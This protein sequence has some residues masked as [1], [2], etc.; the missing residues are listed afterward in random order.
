MGFDKSRF[1]KDNLLLYAVT[2]RSCLHGAALCDRVE[3]ALKGGVTM[4]QLR[5]KGMPA[6]ELLEEAKQMKALCARY[7]VP[8]II[9]DN[10]EVAKSADADG[11][12]I[13]QED[14]DVPTA[15]RLL[16]QD[17]LIGVSA[18]TVEQA[19]LAWEQGADYLGVGAVFAT[20]TK[21]DAQAISRERLKAVCE[22]VPIPVV[23]IGGITKDNLTYLTGSGISGAA[24]ASAIFA[25]ADT[26]QAATELKERA[27]AAVRSGMTAFSK[28]FLS[29]EQAEG[30]I[31]DVD[32]TLLDSMPA[33]ANSGQQYLAT[34]GI[35]APSSLGKVLFS[36]TMQ[37]GAAYIRQAF[38]LSQTPE[39]IKA[40]IIQV[41]ERA[42]REKVVCKPGAE[43]FLK[44]LYEA[45]IPMAVVTSND[46]PLV[47]A[48]FKRLHLTPYFGHILTC[49]E[50]G[51]GK[52][53]PAIFHAA[54]K[55]LGS[56][57]GHTWI[58]EDG[59][60]AIRTAKQA[61]YRTI[62]VAD[63]ASRQDE[64]AIRRLSDYFITDFVSGGLRNSTTG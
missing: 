59:L 51:S 64:E 43:A 32:G 20:G 21:P 56:S 53:D 4:V 24:A 28:Q 38:G 49:G 1:S 40:G 52:D 23:A 44:A 27:K 36:M 30:V 22:A 42:Y 25:Q 45:G 17:K 62:G 46:K 35:Q 3:Q 2:D 61:G 16:G 9:N 31:F 18:R 14:M 54:A 41:V 34:L 47:L 26:M 11:V 57:I 5:E 15:R 19:V 10:V 39:E 12:H 8:L 13:G 55:Q 7:G 63:A 60:Y 58:V 48:A 6:K 29:R 50:F 37:K 33:W